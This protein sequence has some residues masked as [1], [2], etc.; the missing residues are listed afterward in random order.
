[1]SETW[2]NERAEHEMRESDKKIRE[3]AILREAEEKKA[4]EEKTKNEP[5]IYKTSAEISEKIHRWEGEEGESFTDYFMHDRVNNQSWSFWLLGKGYIEHA[6]KLITKMSVEGVDC[7]L[8]QEELYEIH[9]EHINGNWSDENHD[10]NI[11]I[12]SEFLS[13]STLYNERVNQFFNDKQFR[14]DD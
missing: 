4:L 6:N 9:G 1:M 13:D 10:K 11:K 14:Q 3:A 12:W 5:K 7:Y 8:D 2:K